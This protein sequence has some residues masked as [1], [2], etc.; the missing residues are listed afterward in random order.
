MLI[1]ISFTYQG[2][3]GGEYYLPVDDSTTVSKNVSLQCS[4]FGDLDS[5]TWIEA[6][7]PSGTGVPVK[8]KP[9]FIFSSLKCY[10]DY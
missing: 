5:L 2:K 7:E 1:F 8:V 6:P 4:Q 3:W 10:N 9:K